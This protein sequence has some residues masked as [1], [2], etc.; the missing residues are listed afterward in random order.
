MR[1][2]RLSVCAP[3]ESAQRLDNPE[4]G[5]YV[6]RSFAFSDDMDGG[7]A[8]AD[9]FRWEEGEALVL[10]EFNLCRYRDGGLSEAALAQ[11]DVLLDGL[12]E[13][14]KQL[15]VRFAYDLEGK[16]F[17]TEP[18]SRAIVTRHME[19]TGAALRRH[20][21]HIFTL[22]GLFTG[23][24]GEMNGTRYACVDDLRALSKTL[25]A[26]T[27][28]CFLAVRT[29]EQWR[30]IVPE[31]DA[32]GAL[33][34]RLGLFNDG[35][36]GS[37]SDL[38]TYTEQPRAGA[39]WESAWN[40]ED[41]LAFQS[42]LCRR[43]PNGG[44]V[45][46]GGN[47][48]LRDAAQ[49][50]RRMRVSYLNRD[51]DRA[52]MDHWAG[53]IWRERGV[54]DGVSGLDYIEAHLGYRF[55]L[56]RVRL[57]RSLSGRRLRGAAQMR[58]VGFA[59]AYHAVRAELLLASAAGRRCIPLD[60]DLRSLAGGENAGERLTLRWDAV[61]TAEEAADCRICIRVF[62]EKYKREILLGNTGR[63]PEGG[64]LIGRIDEK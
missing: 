7:R 46:F 47:C 24:W 57:T 23:N 62:S 34:A 56:D 18:Q 3:R 52:V 48:A 2:G 51:Y 27:D 13:R 58:N 63:E 40:R 31:R 5:F 50:L 42:E 9:A 20:A 55:V 35:I 22:Q 19:Q 49:A 6:I 38:G 16:N 12:R 36:L 54:F 28:G 26:Q 10:A 44:E 8:L 30:S 53:E 59:P 25:A 33:A 41:E 29:P 64:Y 11:L 37:E 45:V 60:G 4:R 14:G 15:I 61:L 1:A 39:P 17:Q 43:V 21:D 32:C